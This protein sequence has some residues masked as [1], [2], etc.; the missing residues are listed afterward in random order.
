MFDSGFLGTRA[1]FYMDVVTLYF[2]L[3]PL[4]LSWG[5]REAIKGHIRRHIRIQLG[6]FFITFLCIVFFETAVR[7]DGGFL[8]YAQSSRFSLAFL[9][10]YLAL[11]SSIAIIALG[12]WMYLIIASVKAYR[13]QGAGH[14][15]FA[16]HKKIAKPLF[17]ALVISA[18]MG[19]GFYG[20]LFI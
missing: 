4:L 18:L 19:A 11:H 5:I 16:K 17:F 13:Q 2:V 10:F 12:G 15:Y 1:P 9:G 8:Y 14:P 20:M 7:L 6:V 3:L